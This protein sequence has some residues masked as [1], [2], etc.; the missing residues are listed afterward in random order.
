MSY[1]SQMSEEKFFEH[2]RDAYLRGVDF[3]A[4]IFSVDDDEYQRLWSEYV[5]KGAYDYADKVT[6]QLT[7]DDAEGRS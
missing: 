2:L 7:D 3:A 4:E 6:S 5:P 1:L